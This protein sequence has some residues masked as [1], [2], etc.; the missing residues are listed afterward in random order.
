[1][2]AGA[3]EIVG[4]DYRELPIAKTVG[5]ALRGL[6]RKRY[7]SHAAKRIERD[8]DL[9][10]KT[11]RNVVTQGHV[12]ERTITKAIRA[13]GWPLLMALGAELTGETFEQY[14]VRRL[15]Q[16]IKEAED[17]RQ[18]ILSLAV[19]REEVEARAR[20]AVADLDRPTDHALGGAESRSWAPLDERGA[21]APRS[22]EEG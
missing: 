4:Q 13:E 10:P 12:S 1:M 22:A 17:A 16:L 9:D 7:A 6:I 14:E 19:R 15:N 8:W 3:W 5:D 18:N 20:R 2:T 11:A 21:V